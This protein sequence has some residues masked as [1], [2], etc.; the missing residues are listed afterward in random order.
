[1]PGA[2]R[3]QKKISKFMELELQMVLTYHLGAGNL[4]QVF[5]AEL[6]LSLRATFSLFMCVCVVE[7][8]W[9]GVCVC[10]VRGGHCL[11]CVCSVSPCHFFFVW[12]V[13]VSVVWCVLV[14]KTKHGLHS[15]YVTCV[16]V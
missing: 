14:P 8:V 1:M 7:G 5:T 13:C 16:C 4:I 15:L 9:F 12:G 6:C 3:S 10:V 2:N 11:G